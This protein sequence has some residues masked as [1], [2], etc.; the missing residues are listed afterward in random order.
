V[1]AWQRATGL[2]RGKLLI[3]RQGAPSLVLPETRVVA[4]VF[5]GPK[6][7]TNCIKRWCFALF[8]Y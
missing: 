8:G 5:S 7:F 2:P 4:A 6:A 3:T 1:R